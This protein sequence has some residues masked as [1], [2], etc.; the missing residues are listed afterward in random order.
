MS[1][2]DTEG[3]NEASQGDVLVVQPHLVGLDIADEHDV[4]VEF[5]FAV[6]LGQGSLSSSHFGR[7]VRPW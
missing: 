7:T 6:D 4:V 1:H 5:A 3:G 2:K